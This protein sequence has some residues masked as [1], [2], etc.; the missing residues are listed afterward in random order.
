MKQRRQI[1]ILLIIVLAMGVSPGVA[2]VEAQDELALVLDG[3]IQFGDGTI[4]TSALVGFAPVEDTGQ[5]GCWDSSGNAIAC[6]GTGQDGEIQAGADWP[7]PRF[8][9][10]QDGTVSDVLTG[11]VWLRDADCFGAQEWQDALDLTNALMDG[12]CD[13]ADGS[14]ATEWRL[15]NVKEMFSLIDLGHSSPA[16]IIGHPFADVRLAFYWTSTS[17][18][19]APQNAWA[20]G[21]ASGGSDNGP[22]SGRFFSWPVRNGQ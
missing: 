3:G 6:S 7:S 13:L 9:D 14:L 22:K 16:I 21:L 19:E 12:T 1:P 10:N 17:A 15:P 5:K 2:P 11:L 18:V 20:V 8:V 4:Q